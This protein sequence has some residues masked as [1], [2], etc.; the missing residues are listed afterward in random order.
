MS[1]MS[2][3]IFSSSLWDDLFSASTRKP[4]KLNIAI[5]MLCFFVFSGE[6]IASGYGYQQAPTEGQGATGACGPEGLL[7]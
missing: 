6:T 3:Y 4:E 7:E 1:A 5:N 2:R